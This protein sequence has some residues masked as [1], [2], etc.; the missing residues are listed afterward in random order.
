MQSLAK[1][2]FITPVNN[3]FYNKAMSTEAAINAAMKVPVFGAHHRGRL[4]FLTVLKSLHNDFSNGVLNGFF[5]ANGWM[6]LS[7]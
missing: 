3:A 6:Q 4:A 5:L 7:S 2:S 1:H